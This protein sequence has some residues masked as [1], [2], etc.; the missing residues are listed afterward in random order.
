MATRWWLL[1]TVSNNRFLTIGIGITMWTNVLNSGAIGQKPM[2]HA[3]RHYVGA[4]VACYIGLQD[5]ESDAQERNHHFGALV[6][7]CGEVQDE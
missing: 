7:S 2:R 1:Q 6:A 5:D 4:V 3:P